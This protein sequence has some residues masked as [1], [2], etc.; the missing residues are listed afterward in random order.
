M[1]LTIEKAREIMAE[2]D[3]NLDLEGTDITEL[4]DNLTVGGWLD[5]SYTGIT[6]LP[7]SLKVGGSLDL[8]G[9]GITSLPDNLTVGGW[10]NLSY[11]G[12]TSLPDNLTVDGE[13][14]LR[15]T[16]ITSLPSNLT[17]GRGLDLSY[18]G[19]TSLPDNLTVGGWLDLYGTGITSL[20]DNL[21][22]GGGIDLRG[23]G[24]TSLPENLTV[25]GS[26][27]LSGTGITSPAYKRL[28]DGDYVPGRYLYA[29]GIL[30]HVRRCRTVGQYTYYIG[31]ISTKNVVYDGT[32]YAHCRNLRE[33]IADLLY[34]HAADRGAEQYRGLTMD[35]V[36][37]E[38]EAV[39]M[40]R[41]ITGAC[42]AGTRQF[43]ENLK[44]P[45]KSYTVREM[46]ALTRGQYNAERFA[47]FFGE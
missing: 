2:N 16:G 32:Y 39:T 33:G 37:P 31:K 23:T 46:I 6:S 14:S 41:V 35:S 34:K 5:L 29:D 42:Q 45:Q 22:V 47:E 8:E 12:I 36:L 25:G 1:K 43:V 26:L 9:T 17:V 28:K 27:Y 13:L 19:I 15:G 40:Y 7:E 10:L 3:G 24:I 11:M 21:T 4:P 18:M 38:D 20:P 44:N 30:T